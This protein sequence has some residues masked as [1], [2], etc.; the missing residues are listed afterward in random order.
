[1]WN[2]FLSYLTDPLRFLGLLIVFLILRFL[3][4]IKFKRKK[5]RPLV[6]QSAMGDDGSTLPR[7]PGG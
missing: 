5:R 2:Q 1:M 7:E 6:H 4:P 3:T